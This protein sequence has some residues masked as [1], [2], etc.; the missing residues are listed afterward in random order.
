MRLSI[1]FL[2]IALS[3]SNVLSINVPA[4]EYYVSE[5]EFVTEHASFIG[6][7]GAPN[8]PCRNVTIVLPPAAI[9]ESVRFTG[10]RYE[11]GIFSIL[12]AQ[13]ALPLMNDKA[14]KIIMEQYTRTKDKFYSSNNIFPEEHG[15]LL[16]KGGLRKYTLVNLTCYHFAYNPVS[17]KLYCAPNINIEIHYRRREQD[18]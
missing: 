18:A 13:P 3:W 17:K 8:L 6:K 15:V 16:S 9:V 5:G 11:L 14:I 4:P 12:P 10:T 7:T 2:F 1:L